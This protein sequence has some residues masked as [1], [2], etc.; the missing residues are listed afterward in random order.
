M[1]AAIILRIEPNKKMTSVQTIYVCN[2]YGGFIVRKSFLMTMTLLLC[3]CLW[4]TVVS[5]STA[6]ASENVPPV[7]DNLSV[8]TIRGVPL[9]G[10]LAAIDPDGDEITFI[11]T[12]PPGKGDIEVDS[13]GS[14]TYSPF[15]GKRG[16]DY[17][18]YRAVDS[19]GNLSQEATVI[20][21]L[22]KAKTTI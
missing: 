17:F 22:T 9:K 19:Y 20:I 18:G 6:D 5:G 10:Q 1:P 14:F 8:E 16:R 11:I 7:A 3:G 13:D 12:T 4:Y 2:L 15:E 21:K